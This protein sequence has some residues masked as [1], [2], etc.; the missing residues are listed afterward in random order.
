M[1][2][3]FKMIFNSLL[4]IFLFGLLLLPIVSMGFM[5]FR[6]DNK[7]VLSAQDEQTCP[8]LEELKEKA[9]L[10]EIEKTIES[11]EPELINLK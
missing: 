3:G 7:N 11:S 10:E 5:G 9:R 4:T 1:E 2:K 6:P 8:T